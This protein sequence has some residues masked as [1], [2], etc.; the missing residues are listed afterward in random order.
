MGRPKKEGAKLVTLTFK[1]DPEI[2]AAL[3]KL[4]AQLST[5]G[6]LV[7]G[8]RSQAIRKAILEAVTRSDSK[9]E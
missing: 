2:L 5:S 6:G 4:T 8:G 7:N 9:D 3:D 1:A